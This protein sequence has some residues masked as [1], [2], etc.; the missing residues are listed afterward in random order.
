MA[1]VF[2]LSLDASCCPGDTLNKTFPQISTMEAAMAEFAL[3]LWSLRPL[4]GEVEQIKKQKTKL[5]CAFIVKE[6]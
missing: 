3:A 4:S 5:S 2:I 6:H 1:D